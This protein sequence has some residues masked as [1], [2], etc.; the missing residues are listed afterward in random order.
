MLGKHLEAD[1]V[2]TDRVF[3]VGLSKLWTQGDLKIH[4]S[5]GFFYSMEPGIPGPFISD[6]TQ[7]AI[8]KWP[9]VNS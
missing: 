5:L 2:S 8:S 1:A 6:L 3:S 4:P 7:A 9:L